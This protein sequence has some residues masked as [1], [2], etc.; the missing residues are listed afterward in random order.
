MSYEEAASFIVEHFRNFSPKMADFAT[1][2]FNDV[3]LSPKIVPVREWGAS[4]LVFQKR[5]SPEFSLLFRA[6]CRMWQR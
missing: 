3:G 2:A 6:A 5:S 1:M 4:A